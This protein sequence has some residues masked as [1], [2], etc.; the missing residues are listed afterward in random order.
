MDA[1]KPLVI[2][3]NEYDYNCADGCCNYWGLQVMVDGVVMNAD[4]LDV[5]TQ[6][7]QILE[8]LGYRVEI[9]NKYNGEVY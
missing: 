3:F 9:I 7:R 2:E 4:N 8:H 6:V 1:N 5:Q